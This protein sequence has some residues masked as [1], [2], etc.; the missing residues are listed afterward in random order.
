MYVCIIYIYIYILS[1]LGILDE[2]NQR[3]SSVETE[4]KEKTKTNV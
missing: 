3:H 2:A 4:N 1:L